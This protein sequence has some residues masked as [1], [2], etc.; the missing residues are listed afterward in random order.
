VIRRLAHYRL[1]VRRHRPSRRR[2]LQ[3]RQIRH[4]HFYRRPG[5]LA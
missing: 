4:G 3:Q 1:A 5:V 2:P